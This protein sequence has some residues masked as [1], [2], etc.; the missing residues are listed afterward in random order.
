VDEFD[1]KFF[2]ISPHEAEFLDPQQRL[3]LEVAWEALEDACIN[4]QTLYNT[5]AGVFSGAWTLEYKEI[6]LAMK[7]KIS[8][9]RAY[10]G[11]SYGTS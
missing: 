10:M 11:N 7:E 9:F 5:S 4:P 2:G 8:M 3:L 6:L 1:S